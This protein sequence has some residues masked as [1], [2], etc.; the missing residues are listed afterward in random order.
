MRKRIWVVFLVLMLL[1]LAGLAAQEGNSYGILSFDIGYAPL[2]D[3]DDTVGANNYRSPGYFGFNIRVA[4]PV[5]VGFVTYQQPNAISISLLKIRY[6]IIPQARVS[7]SYG[8]DSIAT[9]GS[10]VGFG[11]EGVPFQRKT[12]SLA[13]EFKLGIDYLWLPTVATKD[14]AHGKL[15]F[16]LAVGVG[17]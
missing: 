9:A 16:A 3:F 7:L 4:D 6:D 10:V 13:T 11:I 2:F 12:G 14:I 15:I 5:S 17:I 1:P 8:Y